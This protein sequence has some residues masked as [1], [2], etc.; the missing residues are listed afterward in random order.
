MPDLNWRVAYPSSMP[1]AAVHNVRIV[2]LGVGIMIACEDEQTAQLVRTAWADALSSSEGPVRFT[3]S[4]GLSPS[5]EV[6]GQKVEE[7]LHHLSPAV[8]LRAIEGRAGDLV[9]LHAAALADPETGATAV[10]VAPS[11]TGKTTAAMTLGRRFAYLSDETSGIDANGALV[12]YRKPLSI[13]RGGHLKDQVA[14]TSL[15]MV[16]TERRCHLAALLVLDRDPSHS[17]EPAV[18][19]LDTIEALTL[20]APQASSLGRL[21]RPLHRLVELI[22]RAGGVRHVTYAEAVSLEPVV[23]SLLCETGA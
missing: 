13:I 23:A 17:G 14:P 7:L 9:M 21:D 4:T 15:D 19:E 8:T 11:G 6:T 16:T 2:A 3:L 5:C 18:T 10:L 1:M 12:P 20:L 22:D